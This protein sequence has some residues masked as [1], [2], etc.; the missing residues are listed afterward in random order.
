[1]SRAER[2]SYD[3][4]ACSA[5]GAAEK[6]ARAARSCDMTMEQASFSR[7]MLL[8]PTLDRIKYDEGEHDP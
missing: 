4:A 5:A 7:C 8:T 1:M 3:D 2:T 6:D